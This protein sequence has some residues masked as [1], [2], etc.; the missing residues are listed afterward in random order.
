MSG[1]SS[2][3][4]GVSTTRRSEEGGRR[5]GTRGWA[6]KR[7]W[8]G[9]MVSSR[10]GDLHAPVAMPAVTG[11]MLV[12]VA[13]I[14][15]RWPGTVRQC[16]HGRPP[17]RSAVGSPHLPIRLVWSR[18][19]ALQL[20]FWTSCRP[21]WVTGDRCASMRRVPGH[22]WRSFERPQFDGGADG[23]LLS[24]GWAEALADRARERLLTTRQL[25]SPVAGA[26]AARTE[27]LLALGYGE[28]V[29]PVRRRPVGVAMAS[30]IFGHRSP[31][32]ARRNI[33]ARRGSS[34]RRAC[35]TVPRG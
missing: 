3:G 11:L 33:G 21:S 5:P 30:G 8:P 10:I 35:R 9:V 34:G 32:R 2:P 23:P 27:E 6:R 13:V 26:V 18:M 24:S 1:P 20:G 31:T 29:E 17:V 12:G 22:G 7:R 25:S 4:C 15:K 28:I 14:G 19:R 16:T